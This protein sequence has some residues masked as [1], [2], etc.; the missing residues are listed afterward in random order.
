MKYPLL[1]LALATLSMMIFQ[2]DAIVDTSPPVKPG[3][4]SWA[5]APNTG[6]SA[7]HMVQSGPTKM[8][9]IDK[10]ER[11]IF[12]I[13]KNGLYG[14]SVEYDL[15]ATT[16]PAYH[17]KCEWIERPIYLM[18]PRWYNTMVTLPDGR[19]FIIGGSTAATS[20]STKS[21]QNPTYE[22]YPNIKGTQSPPFDFLLKAFPY[23]LYPHACVLPYGTQ[24]F[25]FSGNHAAIWDY[26]KEAYVKNLPNINGPPRTYPLTG[27][28]LLLPLT[29]E[30][31]YKPEFLVCGGGTKFGNTKATAD[32]TCG[33]IDLSVGKPTWD[34]DTFEIPRVMGDPVILP[35]GKVLIVN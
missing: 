15:T 3:S 26:A 12:A 13:R 2:A 28:G 16:N 1:S 34:Y 22:F 8:L 20:I 32:N 14:L 35:N 7:M 23:N 31:N 11:N 24:L 5:F 19:V 25:L 33:R 27:T 18:S 29:Y 10:A 30:N 4:G 9:I 21:S 17:D 6:V